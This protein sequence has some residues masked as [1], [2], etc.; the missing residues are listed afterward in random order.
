MLNLLKL[1]IKY[2]FLSNPFMFLLVK[3]IDVFFVEKFI[4]VWMKMDCFILNYLD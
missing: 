4:I 2:I 1:K 3:N